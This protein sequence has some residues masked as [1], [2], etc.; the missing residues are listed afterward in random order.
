MG[1]D[2]SMGTLTRDEAAH[3]A[4]LLQ[5]DSY[6]IDLDLTRGDVEFRSTTVI[7]FRCDQ[8]GAGTFVELKPARL[9]HA[10]L[11]GDPLD[12]SSL[13]GNRL[14]MTGLAVENELVVE[15]DMVYSRNGEGLHRFVDPVDGEVYLY[16][17]SFLD[18]AQRIFACFDQP[19]L[20]A[21]HRVSVTA[22]VEWTVLANGPGETLSPGRWEFAQTPPLA[23]Y[24]VTLAAGRT[25]DG[26]W[27]VRSIPTS[28]SC[29]PSPGNAWTG[30]TNCSRSG[31]RSGS[32]TRSSCRSSTPA[33]WKTR[34]A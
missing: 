17:Q 15:A 34:D 6:T 5:V 23:S 24:F 3:R 16:A 11:N 22:P 32:T 27:P 25:V 14:R 28:W 18:D 2:V 31:I 20:K 12:L 26:P 30:T 4:H 9:R 8:P 7:R 21:P 33:P 13:D 1:E 19:D 29:S 10:T